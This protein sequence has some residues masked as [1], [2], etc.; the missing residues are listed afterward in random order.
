MKE[1]MPM[2]IPY[3]HK[4]TLFI[5]VH[6]YKV[7]IDLGTLVIFIASWELLGQRCKFNM[8]FY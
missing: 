4:L 1:K 6:E 8:G 2:G 3:E 5:A 7:L